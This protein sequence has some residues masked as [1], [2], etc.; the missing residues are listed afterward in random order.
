MRVE[1]RSIRIRYYVVM[2]G[3][4]KPLRL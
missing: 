3:F 4:C 2:N 1:I